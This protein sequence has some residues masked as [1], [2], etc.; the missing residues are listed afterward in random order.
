MLD[1]KT[2][3]EYRSGVID[4]LGRCHFTLNWKEKNGTKRSQ[5]FFAN[6]ENYKHGKTLTHKSE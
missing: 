4:T 3:I 5:C 6:P 1:Y 2:K